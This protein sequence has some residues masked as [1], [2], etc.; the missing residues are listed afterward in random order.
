MGELT[1]GRV[2]IMDTGNSRPAVSSN[3][4]FGDET[5]D[6]TAMVVSNKMALPSPISLTRICEKY[7]WICETE[8]SLESVSRVCRK[9]RTRGSDKDIGAKI[10][11][12]RLRRKRSRT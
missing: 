11:R 2:D 1:T 4:R 9:R 7:G 10:R 8:G 6:E 5:K 12:D 3:N